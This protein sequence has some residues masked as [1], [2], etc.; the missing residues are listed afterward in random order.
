LETDEKEKIPMSTGAFINFILAFKKDGIGVSADDQAKDILQKGR[1]LIMNG[2]KGVAI[3]YSANYGQTRKIVETYK[4]GEWFTQ[5]N[6]A[7]QAAVMHKMELLMENDPYHDLQGKLRIAP[8]TT[9][10]G[11]DHSVEPWNDRVHMD[12]VKTDLARIKSYLEA[13]W[14]IL[15][16]QNQNSVNHP[17][18]P[19]AI[20]GGIASVPDDISAEI[21]KSLI[22]FSLDYKK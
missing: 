9:M 1:E 4:K 11:S 5:T 14:D 18:H 13:G 17:R 8:I 3:I 16:W 12:I 6:G 19:Y 10:N 15:G 7:H 20:G 21:Q 2:S 22:Q